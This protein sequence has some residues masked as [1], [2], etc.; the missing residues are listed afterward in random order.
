MRCYYLSSR[1]VRHQHHIIQSLQIITTEFSLYCQ[2][3]N[4]E[5]AVHTTE[6]IHR[7]PVYYLRRVTTGRRAQYMLA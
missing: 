1:D 2:E 4:T 6:K 3:L 7:I 5:L